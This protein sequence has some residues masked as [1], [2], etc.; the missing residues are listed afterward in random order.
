MANRRKLL[1]DLF[2]TLF[3][4]NEDLYEAIA[5]LDY[6]QMPFLLAGLPGLNSSRIAFTLPA[7]Q[8]LAGRGPEAVPPTRAKSP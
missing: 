2:L 8:Q 3:R 1:F 4:S 7:V 6:V 5:S